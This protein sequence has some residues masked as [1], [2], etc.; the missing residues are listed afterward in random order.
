MVS[1]GTTKPFHWGVFLFR[2]NGWTEIAFKHVTLEALLVASNAILPIG[3]LK[4]FRHLSDH[5]EQPH[6]LTDGF[7]F[8]DLSNG[9]LMRHVFKSPH[10]ST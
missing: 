7:V 5:L 3:S 9:E 10:C 8:Y 4:L 1:P 6:L 2:Y